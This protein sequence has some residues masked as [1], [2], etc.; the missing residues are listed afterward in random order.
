MQC[1]WFKWSYQRVLYAAALNH[2]IA[3]AIATYKLAISYTLYSIKIS[4]EANCNI[5]VA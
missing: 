1:H 5:V 4:M 2:D 3:I